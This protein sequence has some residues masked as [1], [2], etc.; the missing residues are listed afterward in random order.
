MT[1]TKDKGGASRACEKL[2]HPIA[3]VT[4]AH[5]GEQSGVAL[6]L[7]RLRHQNGALHRLRH[8][9]CVIRIDDEG[10]LQI[11][12]CAGETRQHQHARV[13]FVLVATGLLRDE[14]YAVA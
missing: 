9:I 1:P 2:L 6:D 7:L 12:R 8:L 3:R 10:F 14:I 5:A 11:F 4:L 13:G